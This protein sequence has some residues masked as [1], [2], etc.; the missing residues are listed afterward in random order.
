M[1]EADIEL[2]GGRTGDRLGQGFV[3]SDNF[4]NC[5]MNW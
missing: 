1:T 4:D 2:G 3:I 5:L